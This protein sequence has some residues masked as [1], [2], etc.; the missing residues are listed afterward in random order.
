MPQDSDFALEFLFS[1]RH[2]LRAARGDFPPLGAPPLPP[3]LLAFLLLLIA[4]TFPVL[5]QAL[6]AK[7]L[8]TQTLGLSLMNFPSAISSTESAIVVGSTRL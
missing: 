1:Y 2:A 3:D 5:P 6:F 4:L 8:R 7:E